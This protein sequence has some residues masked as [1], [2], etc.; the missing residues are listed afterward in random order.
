MNLGYLWAEECGGQDCYEVFGRK[1]GIGCTMLC[2]LLL[3]LCN[4]SSLEFSCS[5]LSNLS[6]IL[7]KRR[8][9]LGVSK[10]VRF[11]NTHPIAYANELEMN[12][13]ISQLEGYVEGPGSLVTTGINKRMMFSIFI[14]F[15][16]GFPLK[17]R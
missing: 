12:R 10:G 1:G 11:H 17:M 14:Q 2:M 9:K 13:L 16:R 8:A 3:G 15:R 5:I 7:E 6:C 4:R